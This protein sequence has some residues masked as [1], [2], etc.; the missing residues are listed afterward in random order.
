MGVILYR[1]CAEGEKDQL[2]NPG[3]RCSRTQGTSGADSGDGPR[4]SVTTNG[5]DAYRHY[6]YL[7]SWD[8]DVDC[9]RPIGASPGSQLHGQ[10]L[11]QH[12]GGSIGVSGGAIRVSGGGANGVSDRGGIR[13]SDTGTGIGG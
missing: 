9:G 13:V 5:I 6:A 8:N 10:Q 11:A 12:V 1:W 7:D 2:G 4:A 3:V